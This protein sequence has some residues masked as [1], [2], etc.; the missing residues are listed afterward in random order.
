MTKTVDQYLA[1]GCGRC[2]LGGTPNCKVHSWQAE[3]RQLRELVLGC[4]LNEESKWGVPCYTYQKK[5]ILII[6][7]FKEY[8][9]ISFFKGSLLSDTEG[10]LDKPGENTQSARLVRFKSVKDISKIEKTVQTYIYEAIEIEK[11]GLKVNFKKAQDYSV[12][13]ELNQKFKSAPGFH[14]AFKALTPGRQKAYLI[15]FSEPKQSKTRLAR[16]EKCLPKIQMGK[17]PN[18]Y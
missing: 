16:I 11:A 6:A 10:I 4:G 13:K 7:A 1:E 8:C 14:T 2:V 18:E 5:N 3:L 9:S 12:P 15:Y 17:G